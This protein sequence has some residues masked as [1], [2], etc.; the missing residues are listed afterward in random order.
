M[1]MQMLNLVLTDRLSL[2]AMARMREVKIA[3]A[4]MSGPAF[5]VLW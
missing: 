3:T 1:V 2:P 5:L 4:T